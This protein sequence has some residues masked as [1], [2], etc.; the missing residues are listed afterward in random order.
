MCSSGVSFS[1][2]FSS[3]I[4]SSVFLFIWICS[5]GV[6][7]V[8]FFIWICPSGVTSVVFPLSGIV[9]SGFLLHRVGSSGVSS[10]VFSSVSAVIT[11]S[12]AGVFLSHFY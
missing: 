9:D 12:F 5:S 10:G 4:I 11:L 1:R 7:A 3:G 2:F 8:F 6:T